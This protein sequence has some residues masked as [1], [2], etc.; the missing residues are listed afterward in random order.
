M[1]VLAR[2]FGGL[3]I[4]PWSKNSPKPIKNDLRKIE[5]FSTGIIP[6][7]YLPS[8]IANS[9]RDIRRAVLAFQQPF[10]EYMET[11]LLADNE[12]G[13]DERGT[14]LR[15][16]I[17]AAMEEAYA[18]EA[19]SYR[20]LQ[21][22][23]TPGVALDNLGQVLIDEA[24]LL[25][26]IEGIEIDLESLRIKH[27]KDADRKPVVTRLQL[28]QLLASVRRPHSED[29]IE[30]FSI[31][32]AEIISVY[33]IDIRKLSKPELNQLLTQSKIQEMWNDLEQKG[34]LYV[35]ESLK[36]Y[37]QKTIENNIL[38]P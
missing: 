22:K 35:S 10:P 14:K 27:L 5:I 21:Q 24:E 25:S 26:P 12:Q 36:G 11:R 29:V 2:E 20:R 23:I 7:Q 28:R 17:K 34:K 18:V 32:V 13:W 9:L 8:A 33:G 30:S 4:P 15:A 38:L 19:E 6:E 31:I 37:I 3:N 16:E 1:V